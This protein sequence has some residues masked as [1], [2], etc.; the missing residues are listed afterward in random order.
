MKLYPMS[1][2][3]CSWFYWLI[4]SEKADIRK[5]ETL[6]QHRT[7]MSLIFRQM[8]Y[9]L[10]SGYYQITS[11][12]IRTNRWNCVRCQGMSVHNSIGIY[13][14][15]KQTFENWKHWSSIE[16]QCSWNIDRGTTVWTLDT[17]K[18]HLLV[19]GRTDET[20]SDVRECL[21]IILLAYTKWKSRHLK[22]GNI[23]P[24]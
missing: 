5:L 24:A 23:E 2:N 16:L 14:V 3:V 22:I 18:L 17:I 1:G 21:F 12:S 8:Y 11:T 7:S 6:V 20:V 10:N 19:L 15:K 9:W 4:Q 13:K